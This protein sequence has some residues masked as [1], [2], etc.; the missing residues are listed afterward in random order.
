ML[1]KVLY[2]VNLSSFVWNDLSSIFRS[3]ET[4][5]ILVALELIIDSQVII[6]SSTKRCIKAIILRKY[7]IINGQT[8]IYLFGHWCFIASD[9]AVCLAKYAENPND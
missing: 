6:S 8:K 2:V 9:G 4:C 3:S 5:H 7:L 1:S